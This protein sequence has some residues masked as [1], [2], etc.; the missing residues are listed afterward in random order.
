MNLKSKIIEVTELS[1]LEIEMFQIPCETHE[2]VTQ[3]IYAMSKEKV[4]QII[5][6]PVE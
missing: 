4:A 5:D 1:G 3:N 2:N 6:T